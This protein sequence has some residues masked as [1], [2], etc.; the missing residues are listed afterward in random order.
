MDTLR[1]G[2]TDREDK[3][4]GENCFSLLSVGKEM[5]L[6]FLV[7][8]ELFLLAMN[9]CIYNPENLIN[10]YINIKKVREKWG[11]TSLQERPQIFFLG[12]S[13]INIALNI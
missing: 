4:A 3:V 10:I 2:E 1:K 11:H 7:L 13:L 12:T 6:D 8:A 9:V 5:V